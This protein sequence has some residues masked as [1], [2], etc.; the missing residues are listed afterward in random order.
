MTPEA[1]AGAD[2]E[3]LTDP[4]E[5]DLIK[6]MAGWP[7][8]VESAAEAHEPHRVAYY[9]HDLANR[10]HVLWNK[11]EGQCQPALHYRRRCRR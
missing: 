2:L 4:A 5:L 11:G 1:L 9:L 6:W 8:L 10:F 7:R 3:R